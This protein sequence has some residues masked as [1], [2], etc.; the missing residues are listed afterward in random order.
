M[1]NPTRRMEFGAELESNRG[2][3]LWARTFRFEFEFSTACWKD[4][5]MISINAVISVRQS[6]QNPPIQNRQ[7]YAQFY[8]A[9]TSQWYIEDSFSWWHERLYITYLYLP[10]SRD[11]LIKQDQQHA[12][13]RQVTSQAPGRGSFFTVV[14]DMSN[15]IRNLDWVG[16]SVQTQS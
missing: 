10:I 8:M 13:D 4:L 11:Q 12:R 5:W 16:K 9:H 1:S 2:L 3:R 14:N 6:I 7:G 15:V